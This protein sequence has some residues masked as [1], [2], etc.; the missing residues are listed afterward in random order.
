MKKIIKSDSIVG[1]I[2]EM[3]FDSRYKITDDRSGGLCMLPES[4]HI[5]K[6]AGLNIGQFVHFEMNEVTNI[7]RK[8]V[9]T[10][11]KYKCEAY[12]DVSH[13]LILQR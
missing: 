10:V 12:D 5:K 3:L 11:T 7:T 6:D 13:K 8:Q 9:S 4:F 1:F 2:N